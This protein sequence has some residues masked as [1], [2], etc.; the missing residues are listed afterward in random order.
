LLPSLNQQQ[1]P[2]GADAHDPHD[3]H[4][5]RATQESHVQQLVLANRLGGLTPQA[6][7]AT[8]ISGTI[9][10]AASSTSR[11]TSASAPA[12]SS[13]SSQHQHN[14]N[15]F[16]SDFEAHAALGVNWVLFGSSRHEVRPPEGPLAAYTSCVPSTHWESTH[17]KV[18]GWLLHPAPIPGCYNSH[19][20]QAL[21]CSSR[22]RLRFASLSST[23]GGVF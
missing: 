6:A 11:A 18:S 12:S 10:Q 5:A 17:V 14:L 20:L 7:A 21:L 23:W 9:N 15:L 16:L 19:S 4:D 3:T 1:Q 8:A 22:V 2:T 13:S